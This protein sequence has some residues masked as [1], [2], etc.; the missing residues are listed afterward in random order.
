MNTKFL[1]PICLLSLFTGLISCSSDDPEAKPVYECIDRVT[2]L[3]FLDPGAVPIGSWQ[4]ANENPLYLQVYQIPVLDQVYFSSSEDMQH[5]WIV[6]AKCDLSDL[7]PDIPNL[8]KSQ[9][10]DIEDIRTFAKHEL[11][12]GQL[13]QR[14]F[15]YDF[16][17]LDTG[18]Y[19]IFVHFKTGEI[20]WKN[21]YKSSKSKEL[22]TLKAQ[23]DQQ[24]Q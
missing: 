6:P 18:F 12:S 13:I 10:I 8:V 17:A 9:E 5:V 11:H 14:Q 3:N 2:G 20:G 4:L 16:S 22:N 23:L 21:V 24:C 7:R 1:L 15:V 19:R